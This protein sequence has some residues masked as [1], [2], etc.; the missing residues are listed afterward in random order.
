MR[1][2]DTKGRLKTYIIEANLILY[3]YLYLAWC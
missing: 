1:P 3:T 2:W